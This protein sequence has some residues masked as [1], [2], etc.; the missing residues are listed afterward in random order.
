MNKLNKR[1]VSRV[2]L[3]ILMLSAVT[4]FTACTFSSSN[5]NLGVSELGTGL[6]MVFNALVNGIVAVIV[7]FFEGLWTFIVGLFHSIMGAI[8]WLWEFIVS[9]F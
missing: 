6:K 3:L 8:A 5:I 4:F 7:G 1:T 9:L 2:M